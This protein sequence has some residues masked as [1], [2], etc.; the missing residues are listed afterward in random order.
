MLSLGSSSIMVQIGEPAWTSAALHLGCAVA[1]THCYELILV[2]MIPVSHV[3]WLGTEFGNQNFNETDR[4][5]LQQ[6]SATAEDYGVPFSAGVYQ[7]FTLSE[8]IVDAAE[9]FNARIVIARLPQY[10]LPFWRR[11]L[12][13]Q[14]RRQFAQQRR[15][16]Y[17][18]DQP[19]RNEP[20]VHQ[21]FLPAA[22]PEKAL[23]PKS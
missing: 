7:Y 2:K 10:K 12:L 11:F 21:I 23:T 14:M 1:R 19:S 16:L 20:P 13:W 22:T 18:L 6:C 8:A 17:T 15:L 9:Y 4:K 5:F 3:G